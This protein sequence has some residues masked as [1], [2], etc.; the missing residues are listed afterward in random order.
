MLT[1]VAIGKTSIGTTSAYSKPLRVNSYMRVSVADIRNTFVLTESLPQPIIRIDSL[2]KYCTVTAPAI[3][4]L[5]EEPADCGS[6]PRNLKPHR[7]P[8]HILRNH[9]ESAVRQYIDTHERL[10][11]A[12]GACHVALARDDVPGYERASP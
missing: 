3:G 9:A 11:I 2:A 12:W 1:N 8:A 7:I 5:Q 6:L 10:D 4:C